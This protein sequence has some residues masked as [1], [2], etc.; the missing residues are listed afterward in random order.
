MNATPEPVVSRIY[1]LLLSPPQT[2]KKSRWASSATSW[3]E[4]PSGASDVFIAP[5]FGS[6]VVAC[7]APK[8]TPACS[9]RL[10]PAMR[11]KSRRLVRPSFDLFRSVGP[12]RSVE[13]RHRIIFAH[14]WPKRDS[15]SKVHST[16]SETSQ[17]GRASGR[18]R[19]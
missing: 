13:L 3:S 12:S 9:K 8:V 16:Y 18:G 17:I 1:F 5:L 2:W 14:P 7:P 11:K 19:G 4:Y 15:H 10:D 6:P